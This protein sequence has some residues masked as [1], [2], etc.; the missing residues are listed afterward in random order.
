MCLPDPLQLRR[1]RC[2]FRDRNILRGRGIKLNNNRFFRINRFSVLFEGSWIS[3]II[4][5]FGDVSNNKSGG[6]LHIDVG[7]QRQLGR[8]DREPDL[9]RDRDPRPHVPQWTLIGCL[10]CRRK[11][12]DPSTDEQADYTQFPKSR[13]S[14]ACATDRGRALTH[15]VQWELRINLGGDEDVHLRVMDRARRRTWA[16]RGGRRA[17]VRRGTLGWARSRAKTVGRTR[18]CHQIKVKVCWVGVAI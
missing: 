3:R 4:F 5:H 7:E 12:A 13:L 15:E 17:G 6:R 11:P 2:R 1:Y 16:S 10:C 9:D 8:A 18:E 14:L